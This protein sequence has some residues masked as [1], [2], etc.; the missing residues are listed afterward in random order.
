MLDEVRSNSDLTRP[1]FAKSFATIAVEQIE[2]KAAKRIKTVA[3]F[4]KQ[5]LELDKY[6][7]PFDEIDE[8]MFLHIACAY[9]PCTYD[10]GGIVQGGDACDSIGEYP[11]KKVYTYMTAQRIGYKYYY[12]GVL[13]EFKQ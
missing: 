8:E 2:K 13:P 5:G 3:K 1:E 10:I 12:L 6:L 9:V 4:E 7:S 11:Q